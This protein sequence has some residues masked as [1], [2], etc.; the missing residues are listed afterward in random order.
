MRCSQVTNQL[1]LYIDHQLS[2][3]RVRALEIHLANCEACQHELHFLEEVATTLRRL[4]SV[5]EPA[6]MTVQIMQRVAMTSQQRNDQYA[7]LRP[8]L[9]EVLVAVFLAT[10]TTLGIIWQQPSL[11]AI[12]PFA[13]GHNTLSQPFLNTLNLLVA[14]N[15][16]VLALALW[17]VG[18]VLGV[19]ITLALVGDEIR[20][21]WFKAMMDRLSVR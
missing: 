6:N 13:N 20:G 18:T 16:S 10:I 19:A 2:T 3:H 21:A 15:P 8:S 14:G 1:Q 4:P 9:L 17:V 5:A 7:L 12:L 11:R